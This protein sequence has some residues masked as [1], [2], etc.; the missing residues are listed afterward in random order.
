MFINFL[1]YLLFSS[2]CTIR[3][4]DISTGYFIWQSASRLSWAYT[5]LWYQCSITIEFQILII[6][7]SAVLSIHYILLL[8]SGICSC[9]NSNPRWKQID[10][11][12]YRIERSNYWAAESQLICTWNEFHN[13]SEWMLNVLKKKTYFHVATSRIEFLI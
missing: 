13:Y 12:R 11:D 6:H 7:Y 3:F 9:G 10:T 5:L 4:R 1:N 2:K 8:P